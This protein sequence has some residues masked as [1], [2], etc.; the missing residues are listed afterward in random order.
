MNIS[1]SPNTKQSLFSALAWGQEQRL[2]EKHQHPPQ[3]AQLHAE[4]YSKWKLKDNP[5]ASCCNLK[6]CYPTAAK[7]DPEFRL[8][9]AQRREDGKWLWIP[10]LVYD[11]DDPNE[12]RSPDGRSHLCAL[13]AEVAKAYWNGREVLC[14]RPGVGI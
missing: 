8:W 2:G 11:E 14:F 12:T 6:D 1:N 13:K 10:K 4:F 5:K 7:F 9:K 3:D